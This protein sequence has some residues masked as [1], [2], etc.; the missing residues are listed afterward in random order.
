MILHAWLRE[1]STVQGRLK[2]D[3]YIRV[4]LAVLELEGLHN[5]LDVCCTRYNKGLDVWSNIRT[6][7]GY[8]ESSTLGIE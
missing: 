5:M 4:G 7:V 8:T 1:F 6:T 2:F 3:C